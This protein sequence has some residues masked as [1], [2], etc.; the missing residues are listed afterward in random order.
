MSQ[1]TPYIGSRI[2][3][4]SKLDIRYEGILYTVDTNESTIALAKVRSFGTEDRPTTNPVAARDDIYEYIIFKATDIKDLIVCET[5]KPLPQLAGGLA[6]DPAILSISSGR[7]I[8]VQTSV[9]NVPAVVNSVISAGCSIFQASRSDTPNRISPAEDNTHSRAPGSGRNQHT[10]SLANQMLPATGIK[11]RGGFQQQLQHQG[12]PNTGRQQNFPS[13][14]SYPGN[15]GRGGQQSNYRENRGGFF[16]RGN[17]ANYQRGGGTRGGVSGKLQTKEKLKF[18]SDYDFEKANE[19]FQETLN[20]ISKMKVEEY[21]DGNKK[22]TPGSDNCS[23]VVEDEVADTVREESE[24]RYYDKSSSFFD[25]ISCEAL[26]KQAGK[27][28]TDWKKERETNQETFGHSAVRSLA[29]RR[30]RG[31]VSGRG[32]GRGG[33]MNSNYRYNSVLKFVKKKTT[34][35]MK[36]LYPKNQA[37]LP[38]AITTMANL[39]VV[40]ATST[41]ITTIVTATVTVPAIPMPLG[42]AVV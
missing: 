36:K 5:P 21:S 12:T 22:A 14:G 7:S 30:P 31:F 26:E 27:P 41:I 18:D 11:N 10:L 4:I 37:D 1:Q 23:D 34:K 39:A 40:T 16:G 8:P 15:Y 32:G 33:P 17:S 38:V 29:Y 9:Q 6:Y 13:V 2:S 20:H 3:L 35:F 28:R 42:K 19:Q 25:R 24:K